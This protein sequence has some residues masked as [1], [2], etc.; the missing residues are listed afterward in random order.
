MNFNT[1]R[2]NFI[3]LRSLKFFELFHEA[4]GSDWGVEFGHDRKFWFTDDVAA[5]CGVTGSDCAIKYEYLKNIVNKF[6]V[7]MTCEMK[8]R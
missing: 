4:F 2:V 8:T 6:S 1:H 5:V 3:E 7:D